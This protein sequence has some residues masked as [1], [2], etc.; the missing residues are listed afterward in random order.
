MTNPHLYSRQQ[1]PPGSVPYTIRAGD[2]LTRIA[3]EYN[4]TVQNIIAANPGI[5]PDYLLVG[6]NICVPMTVQIYPSCPT[7]NY[8]VVRPEDT[9]E[10]IA[11]YFNVTPQQLLY[12][13]YGIDLAELYV[14]Q[15]LCIPV[16]PSP[17]AVE[18]DVDAHRLTV[19]R[20]G[21][22]FKNYAI[23]LEIPSSPVPRGDFE[24]LNK[25]VDPGVELGARWLGLSEAGFGIRGVNSP[26]FIYAVSTGN[27]IVMSNQDVSDLFNL[28]PV[29]TRIRIV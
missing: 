27:S 26:Q 28:I 22:V 19:S 18:I 13:N 12:S 4:T 7:T 3:R 8:Y 6:Q 20:G 9:F 16:A 11:A 25:Q 29:G 17:V 10:S 14:D 1:C 5:D 23:A 2:T 15:V 21:N 24:V